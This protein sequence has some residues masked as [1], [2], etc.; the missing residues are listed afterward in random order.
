[1]VSNRWGA[2]RIVH[3]TRCIGLAINQVHFCQRLPLQRTFHV[4]VRNKK[5]VLVGLLGG[6]GFIFHR[7]G[8]HRTHICKRHIMKCAVRQIAVYRSGNIHR[9]KV[10]IVSAAGGEGKLLV[11]LVRQLHF[12]KCA[13]IV[14][15]MI[16]VKLL[17]EHAERLA[18]H[19]YAGQVN[20]CPAA[21]TVCRAVQLHNACIAGNAPVRILNNGRYIFIIAHFCVLVFDLQHTTVDQ[22]RLCRKIVAVA[23]M[24]GQLPFI[25][26]VFGDRGR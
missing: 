4:I 2:E 12:P 3:V 15:L 6:I 17:V 5:A 14:G 24:Q 19:V 20:R 8:I 9:R 11:D 10:K 7:I 21:C 13:G 1:M 25:S 26:G 23:V 18:G 22:H 16:A